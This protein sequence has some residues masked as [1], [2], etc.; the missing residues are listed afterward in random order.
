MSNAMLGIFVR[1]GAVPAFPRTTL[2]TPG[3]R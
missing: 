3:Y 1:T 2:P